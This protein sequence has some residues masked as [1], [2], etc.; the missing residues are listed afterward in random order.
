MANK[1]LETLFA[2]QSFDCDPWVGRG[3]IPKHYKRLTCSKEEALRLAKIGFIEI[4]KYYGDSLYFTQS[5]I[6]GAVLSGDYD[7]I[8]VTTPSSY[9]KSFLF[10]KGKYNELMSIDNI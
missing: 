4:A 6:A 7:R 10:G 1:E 8:T 3:K 2:L 9:G 5:L